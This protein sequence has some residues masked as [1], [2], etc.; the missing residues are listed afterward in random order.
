MIVILVVT[1]VFEV[2]SAAVA[3]IM[4]LVVPAIAFA[5][6]GAVTN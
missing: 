3:V 1:A 2:V 4:M 5:M 6:V